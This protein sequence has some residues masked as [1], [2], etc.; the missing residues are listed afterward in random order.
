MRRFAL[1]IG[2]CVLGGLSLIHAQTPSSIAYDR[3]RSD[4]RRTEA[5]RRRRAYK[6]G[7]GY[8][9]IWG[10]FEAT[11]TTIDFDS[12]QLGDVLKSMTVP[13]WATA[14]SQIS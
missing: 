8:S 7:V 10:R 1:A 14:A 13:I 4:G 2:V 6:N 11:K 12:A 3:P 9:N 5:A